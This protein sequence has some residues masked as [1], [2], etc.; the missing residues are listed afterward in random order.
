METSFDGGIAGEEMAG[1][2]AGD[3][4]WTV[5]QLHGDG[6][7]RGFQFIQGREKRHQGRGVNFGTKFTQGRELRH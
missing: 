3:G 4:A 1:M 7:K 5:Q 2:F 6:S